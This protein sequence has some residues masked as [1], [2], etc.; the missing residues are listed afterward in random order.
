MSDGT[1][2]AFGGEGV[3]I[4]SS[5]VRWVRFRARAVLV[6]SSSVAASNA[7]Q[8]ALFFF[9]CAS[10]SPAISRGAGMLVGADRRHLE[11]GRRCRQSNSAALQSIL[12]QHGPARRFQA[13]ISVGGKRSTPPPCQFHPRPSRQLV[14]RPAFEGHRAALPNS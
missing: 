2:E 1:P 6:S 12:F 5:K 3:L 4:V 14:L 10:R 8:A 9:C 11:T 13:L 7:M